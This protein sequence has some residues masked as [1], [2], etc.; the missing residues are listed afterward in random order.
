MGNLLK[1]YFD[2]S[3]TEKRGILILVV[4]I[5]IVLSSP[6]VYKYFFLSKSDNNF[7]VFQQEIDALEASV[8][9]ANENNNYKNYKKFDY[10][11]VDKS[12][13]EINLTPFPFDPNTAKIEDFQKMG[14]SEKQIKTVENYRN[15]GGTYYKKEDFA[16]M[17]CINEE[18]YKILEPF[19]SIQ[20]K[21]YPKK[22]TYNEDF[23]I[24]INAATA[25]ELTK[26]KG[27]G[28][29]YS[30]RIVKY[31]DL[32]GGYVNKYQLLEVY[33]MDSVRFNNMIPFVEI[34]PYSVVKINVNTADFKTLTAHPY[35][36]S[37]IALSIINYREMHGEYQRL[38]EIKASVL[39]DNQMYN[40]ISPYLVVE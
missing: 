26:I 27:I 22:D 6:F 28:S 33:G 17:Y 20:Q 1:D 21:E 34:N 15:K 13:A 7:I 35:I 29:S 32:L 31:R 19:I 11:D 3:K 8:E 5:T 16:K 12:F 39:I 38:E 4:I 2:I 23:T 9:S 25:E 24:E 14:F 40:K 37:N 30:K 36:S 18:E 10:Y